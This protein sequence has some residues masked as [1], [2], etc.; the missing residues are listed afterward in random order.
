MCFKNPFLPCRHEFTFHI[1]PVIGVGKW[2]EIRAPFHTQAHVL[3]HQPAQQ[4]G[5][6][7]VPPPPCSACPLLLCAYL[8]RRC[9]SQDCRLHAGAAAGTAPRPGGRPSPAAC[10]LLPSRSAGR[11]VSA[12]SESGSGGLS[13]GSGLMTCAGCCTGP[14]E[15]R[16]SSALGAAEETPGGQRGCAQE[17]GGPQPRRWNKE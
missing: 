10:P 7:R 3:A 2:C 16:R 9:R 15:G 13:R 6:S 5:D 11:H 1:R 8:S 17:A 14:G 12:G 4:F